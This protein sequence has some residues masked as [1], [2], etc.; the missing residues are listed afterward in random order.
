MSE[1]VYRGKKGWVCSLCKQARG[2]TGD[3]PC[4]P[5]LPGVKY[6]CCGHGGDGHHLAYLYFQNGTRI[7]M[8]VTSVSYDDGRPSIQVHG[9]AIRKQAGI[10]AD[11]Q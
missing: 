2:P 10:C 11:E 3:D 5:A 6:A 7:G 4:I 9:D 8:I 1:G